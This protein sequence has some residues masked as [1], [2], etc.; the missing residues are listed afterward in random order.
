MS[1]KQRTVPQVK[2]EKLVKNRNPRPQTCGSA[3]ANRAVASQH[4][5]D[6]QQP[7]TPKMRRPNHVAQ[8]DGSLPATD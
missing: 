5:P 8:T 3:E 2:V 1:D 7:L 6:F 4:D